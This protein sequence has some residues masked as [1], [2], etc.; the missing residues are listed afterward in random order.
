MG[1][2]RTTNQFVDVVSFFA[3]QVLPEL[4]SGSAH[5]VL[6]AD[7][8]K[9]VTTFRNQLPKEAIEVFPLPPGFIR[10]S[11]NLFEVSF[12]FLGS[13]MPNGSY[14]RYGG[15]GCVWSGGRRA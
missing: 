11:I 3:A 13:A 15:A 10:F 8:F 1:G 12:C 14:V 4:Q 9:F 5:D 2:A 7:A 6:K